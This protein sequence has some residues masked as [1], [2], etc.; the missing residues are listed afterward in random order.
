MGY[1]TDFRGTF[2]LDRPLNVLQF[3]TLKEFAEEPHNGYPG[4]YCQWIPTEDGTGLCWDGNEKFYNYTE[5]LEHIV[6][7]FLK[8]WGLVLNGSVTWHGERAGDSGV[9]YVKDNRV[10]AV[11]D[12]IVR[13]EPNWD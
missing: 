7:H 1:T 13:Q 9:I 4:G 6:E 12:E 10:K 2:K 11:P 3:T 8:P 5:W